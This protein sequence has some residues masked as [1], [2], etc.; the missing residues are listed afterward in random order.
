MYMKDTDLHLIS[1]G[2]RDK[3]GV[4]LAKKL[5][6]SAVNAVVWVLCKNINQPKSSINKGGSQIV[7]LYCNGADTGVCA[8]AKVS[9]RH[10]SYATWR[11]R[12]VSSTRSNYRSCETTCWPSQQDQELINGMYRAVRWT[13]PHTRLGLQDSEYVCGTRVRRHKGY[14]SSSWLARSQLA[15][16]LGLRFPL[17]FVIDLCR[18]LR[19]LWTLANGSRLIRRII[20]LIINSDSN[21]FSIRNHP[22][23]WTLI[24]RQR[25]DTNL[26]EV[27][28]R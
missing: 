20:E 13:K 9:W 27:W 19:T 28:Q 17:R 26:F 5:C 3:A 1:H 18:R 15:H 12:A 2:F 7:K 16:K 24:S 10:V 21:W 23:R 22:A 8:I 25:A 14:R 6:L 4:L 11:T